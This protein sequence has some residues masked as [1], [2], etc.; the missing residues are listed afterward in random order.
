MGLSLT[1]NLNI[2]SKG[3]ACRAEAIGGCLGLPV[4]V[5]HKCSFQV[6]SSRQPSVLGAAKMVRHL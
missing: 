1:F 5:G 4:G 6:G 3:G 2:N